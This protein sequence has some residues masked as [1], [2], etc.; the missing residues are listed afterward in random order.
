MEQS[1]GWLK[2]GDIKRE[3]ESTVVTAQGQLFTTI[4]IEN[5]HY[6]H[7]AQY[8]YLLLII[9]ATCYDRNCWP[10]SGS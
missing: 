6:Q 8:L 5:L 10:S 4:E 9:A 7:V 1:F 2:F 3:I